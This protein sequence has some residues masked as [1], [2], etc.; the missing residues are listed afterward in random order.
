[1]IEYE[2][3]IIEQ[4]EVVSI[5]CDI[6]KKKYSPQTEIFETQEFF[7]IRKHCGY[8]SV[9]GDCSN[10]ELDICQHCMLDFLQEKGV[11]CYE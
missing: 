7:H 2:K 4:E 5:K 8:S 6:C 10:V 1:M 9:F 3:K 11:K